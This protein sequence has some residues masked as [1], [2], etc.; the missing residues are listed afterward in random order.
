MSK[1]SVTIVIG[2]LV[3]ILGAFGFITSDE[4]TKVNESAASIVSA[5]LGL[6]ELVRGIKFRIEGKSEESL[7]TSKTN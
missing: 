3:A 6:V 4:A 1:S 5:V 2:A 7:D